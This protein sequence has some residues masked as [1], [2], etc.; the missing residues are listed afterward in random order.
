MTWV[1]NQCTGLIT[2]LLFIVLKRSQILQKSASPAISIQITWVAQVWQKGNVF[3]VALSLDN[4]NPMYFSTLPPFPA[5][6]YSIIHPFKVLL[7]CHLFHKI[8]QSSLSLSELTV[9]H[10]HATDTY[11]TVI[12]F[13]LNISL[14]NKVGCSREMWAL[15]PG[16]LRLKLWL[17]DRGRPLKT[18]WSCKALST[19]LI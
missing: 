6:R 19:L 3:Q 16:K 15:K 17:R 18:R 2:Y 10:A 12:S 11:F 7:K 8:S 5:H 9:L 4:N 13:I 1:R 14:W